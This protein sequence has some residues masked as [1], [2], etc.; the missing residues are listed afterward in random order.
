MPVWERP[1]EPRPGSAALAEFA[2][3]P[4]VEP[5]QDAAKPDSREPAIEFTGERVVPGQVDPDL[6]NEHMARYAFAARLARMKR[7]LDAGSGAGYGSAELARHASRVVGADVSAEAVA[8]A[9]ERYKLPN[10]VFECAS[11]TALPHPDASFDLVVAFEIIEHL[12]NWRDLLAEARR[13]LAPGGQFVVSTPNREYYAEHRRLAGP[14]PYHVHE[15]D[16]E[17]F[18]AALGEFFPHISMFLENHA[19]GVVFQPLEP[20]NTAH[21]QVEGTGADPSQS[22]FFVAVCANRPQTG[23]PSFVYVP[24]SAN[25]LRERERHIAL[26]ESELATKDQWL[27]TA[28]NQ[29]GELNRIHQELIAMHRGQK[30]E[31]EASNRWAESLNEKI[32]EAGTAIAELEEAAARMA[33][34]YQAKVAELEEENRQKTQ[35]VMET[36]ERLGTELEARTEE[37]VRSVELLHDAEKTIEERTLWARR[38]ESQASELDGHLS[39]V[40]GSRWFKLGRRFGLGPVLPGA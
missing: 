21:V 26:L 35:W 28:R 13:L 9:S 3:Q 4:A 22:H 10:V 31:L 20:D 23:A 36:E 14:N 5:C 15:F 30:Q 40:K 34:E 8:F 38:L 32:R 29:L 7:V 1:P 19:Q 18:R 25:L 17:E 33:G 12:E 37:L 27:T 24:R 6:M 11:C 16:F 39:M 2:E